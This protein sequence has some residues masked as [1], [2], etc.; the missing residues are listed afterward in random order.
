MDSGTPTVRRCRAAYVALQFAYWVN[1]SILIGFLLPYLHGLG[2]RD[3]TAGFLMA[4]GSLLGFLLPFLIS[5]LSAR[6]GLRLLPLLR[7]LLTVQLVLC[8][9]LLPTA[10]DRR[11]LPLCLLLTGLHMSLY[12]LYVTLAVELRRRKLPLRFSAARAVG[13]LGY[14]LMS[15]LLGSTAAASDRR[16]GLVCACV[17][18]GV[19]LLLLCAFRDC[20]A[21]ET[22][23]ESERD[24]GS[25]AE[26]AKAAPFLLL[27][28]GA[29][30]IFSGDSAV[31]SF[32][33]SILLSLG[34]S[35][36][37]FGL[38]TAFKGLMEIPVML[39]YPA[40]RR[41]GSGRLLTAAMCV[42]LVKLA[43]VRLAGSVGMLYA[44]FALQAFS[45]GLYAPAIVD[46]LDEISPK[47]FAARAQ[48]LGNG[49]NT[50][51]AFGATVLTGCLLSEYSVSASLNVLLLLEALGLAFYFAGR[52]KLREVF[53]KEAPQ[54]D[55]MKH[56][57]ERREE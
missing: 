41:L 34:E 40:L 38:L 33:Y 7:G 37:A 50:F 21:G 20:L 45:F 23:G 51:G 43:L 15:L 28:L 36:G 11:G 49:M 13:S 6:L 44:A 54:S 26:S 32:R 24:G 4:G 2:F 16:I 18:L 31:N 47:A 46:F 57:E 55:R 12:P 42:F 35:L 39:L 27:L 10:A 30:L 56:Q 8:L 9:L 48:S 19:Q 1:G 53:L 3:D 17:S 52:Q 5:S 25:G 29:A 22:E 14:A